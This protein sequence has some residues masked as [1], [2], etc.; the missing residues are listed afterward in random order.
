M[1][2]GGSETVREANLIEE[3][4]AIATQSLHSAMEMEESEPNRSVFTLHQSVDS[5]SEYCNQE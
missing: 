1:S 2:L 5:T 3:I 4:A